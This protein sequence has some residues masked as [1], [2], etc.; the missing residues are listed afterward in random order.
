MTT[1]PLL[2]QYASSSEQASP[3]SE[4]QGE[5]WDPLLLHFLNS[6]A[7]TKKVITLS[8]PTQ[9]DGGRI[10]STGSQGRQEEG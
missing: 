7:E 5:M 8:Q 9:G 2:Q 6:N 3:F 4:R 10:E 1:S